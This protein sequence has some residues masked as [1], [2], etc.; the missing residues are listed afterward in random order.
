[1]NEQMEN[2]A[3]NTT[4]PS[5]PSASWVE[6]PNQRGTYA[7][8]S[9]CASTMTICIWS[10]V[11]YGIPITRQ[12]FICY[13]LYSARW[14]LIALFAPE[15][16]LYGAVCERIDAGHLVKTATEYLPSQPAKPGKLIRFYN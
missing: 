7:I 5:S 15:V 8:L 12:S 11:H 6:E 13:I 1:M 14:M 9:L 2:P 3:S 10:A 4:T 16:L